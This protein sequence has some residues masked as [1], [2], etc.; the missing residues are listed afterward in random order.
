MVVAGR[1]GDTTS[2]LTQGTLP[3]EILTLT[4]LIHLNPQTTPN[5]AQCHIVLDICPRQTKQSKFLLEYLKTNY[6][7]GII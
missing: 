5:N 1:Q 4:M 6:I 7:S 3:S 2:L